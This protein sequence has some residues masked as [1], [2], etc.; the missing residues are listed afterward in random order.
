MTPFLAYLISTGVYLS[1]AQVLSK[2]GKKSALL[3]QN[4][5]EHTDFF[6]FPFF[7]PPHSTTVEVSVRA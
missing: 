1:R 2:K 6:V 4:W 5:S 3:F 7:P